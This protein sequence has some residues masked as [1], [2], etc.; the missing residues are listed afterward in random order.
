MRKLPKG[1]YAKEFREQAVK[2][3]LEEGLS[4]RDAGQRLSLSS[5]ALQNGVMAARKSTLK[6]I[7]PSYPSQ[8][9]M[10][11]ELARLKRELA[12]VKLE[13]DLLK[14]AAAYCAKASLQGT[15]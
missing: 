1:T 11:L 10:E 12:E 6:A 15:R 7:G 3:V 13:R 4:L 5:K 14:K 2:W 8:T 9:E